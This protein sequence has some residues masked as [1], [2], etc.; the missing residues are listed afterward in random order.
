MDLMLNVT[1][2][3]AEI[4]VNST[5]APVIDTPSPYPLPRGEGESRSARRFK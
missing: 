5:A 4:P 3:P 2:G 1:T